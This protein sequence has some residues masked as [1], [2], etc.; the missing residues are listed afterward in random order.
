MGCTLPI[1]DIKTKRIISKEIVTSLEIMPNEE[2]ELAFTLGT[3]ADDKDLNKYN[4]IEQIKL[5]ERKVTKYWQDMLEIIQ[6][7]TGND[8]FDYLLNGWLTYQAIVSRLYAKAGFY[9][10]GGAYGYRDQL[11]DSMNIC[12]IHPEITKN[13]ILF[14]AMHQF[15]EGDVLHWWHKETKIGLR[16]KYKDDY[17]W[18]V[19]AT[20]EYLNVTDDYKILDEQICFVDGPILTNEEMEKGNLREGQ[21]NESNATENAKQEEI[22]QGEERT[23][24]GDAMRR[25]RK[26]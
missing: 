4:S 7:K 23:P 12:I 14:N 11:Q 8:S 1:E 21:T 25:S 13:Q 15:K 18:L 16:S 3:V 17:L 9:Q 24:W 10:V 26:F 2:V 6:V 5:E 19:Y 20:S 22:N